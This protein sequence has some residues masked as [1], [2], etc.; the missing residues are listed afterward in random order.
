M[1]A[2]GDMQVKFKPAQRLGEIG[3]S[4]IM[5]ITMR[6][7]QLVREGRD[8]ISLGAGEPDFDT[9][10]HI[11]EAAA[12]AMWAGAT[13]YTALDGTLELKAAIREKFRREN[14]LDYALDEIQVSAGAKHVI[15]NA[16]MASLNPGDEVIIPVPYWSSYLD[17]VLIAGGRPVPVPCSPDGMRLTADALERAITPRTRWLILNSPSNPSGA[18]YSAAQYQPL[19]E[20]LLRHPHVW[21]MAD[22]IYEH[23]VYDGFK[24]TTPAALAPALKTRTLTVNGVSKAYAMTGWRIG[25]AAG[26]KE[27]IK[28]MGVVQSQVTSSA[29]SVSQAAAVAALNGPQDIVRERCKSFQARRDLIVGALNRIN[30]I[31]CAKPEGAFYVFGSCEGLIGRRTPTGER[32][33][34]DAAFAEFLLQTAEVAL[35]PG[36]A[37]GMSPYFRISYVLSVSELER[38]SQRIA[39]ACATLS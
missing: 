24:F 14:G 17:I 30:G 3:V 35:V 25:Y 31:R 16:L 27:L 13:K 7:N 26:P 37:F 34:S 22:D 39:K 11:K 5:K 6:A 1:T 8:V 23:I 10:D 33:E 19:L 12:K 28:G 2:S 36:T 32:I 38:A 9:P 4:P 15:F 21:L 18:A 29:S 20:V